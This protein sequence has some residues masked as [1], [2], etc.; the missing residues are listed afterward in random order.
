[1]ILLKKKVPSMLGVCW[2]ILGIA[3]TNKN[4][5]LYKIHIHKIKFDFLVIIIYKHT[6][7]VQRKENTLCF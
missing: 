3:N 1:M 5:G 7:H 6:H 2:G 4:E